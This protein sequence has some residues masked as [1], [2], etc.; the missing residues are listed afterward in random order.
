MNLEIPRAIKRPGDGAANIVLKRRAMV[1]KRV[2]EE[3][4]DVT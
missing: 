1:S 4:R 2:R 3:V